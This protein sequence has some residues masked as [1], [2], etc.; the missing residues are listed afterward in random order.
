MVFILPGKFNRPSNE[1]TLGHEK[2]PEKFMI[3]FT[4]TRAKPRTVVVIAPH[5]ATT[6]LT[7]FGAE[8]LKYGAV[9]TTT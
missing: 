3:P 5:A 8:R 6:V 9:T 4:N 7:V 1:D 2:T